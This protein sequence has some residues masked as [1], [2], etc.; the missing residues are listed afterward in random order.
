MYNPRK[1]TTDATLSANGYEV[2]ITDLTQKNSVTSVVIL[3][4]EM[5]QQV[6]CEGLPTWKYS[7]PVYQFRVIPVSITKEAATKKL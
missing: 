7:S 4:Q 1:A 6:E 2:T 3:P 5:K